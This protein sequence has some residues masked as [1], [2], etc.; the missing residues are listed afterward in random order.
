MEPLLED[1]GALPKWD[2]PHY[3]RVILAA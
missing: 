1:R 3:Q 2:F